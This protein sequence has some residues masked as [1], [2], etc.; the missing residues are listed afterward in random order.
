VLHGGAVTGYSYNQANELISEGSLIYTYSYNGDGL[1][2][3]K[4]HSV[5][6]F[7]VNEDYTWDV[8]AGLPLLLQDGTA[9]YIYGPGGQVLEQV[10]ADGTVYYDHTD[11]LGSVRDVTDSSGT[12]QNSYTYDPY[13]SV[14]AS[15]GSVT[16]PFQYAGE[17]QDAESGLIYLRARY[18]DPSTAQFLTRDSLLTE[19]PYAYV[20]GG[21]LTAVDPS[22]HDGF[23]IGGAALAASG[24]PA[25]MQRKSYRSCTTQ[26]GK[27]GRTK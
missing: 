2:Y 27:R 14:R 13:G 25:Q 22:G 8:M 12:V 17:Y 6:P 11:Q 10:R 3:R 26:Q 7:T 5:G 1:R 4:S 16:N 19:L 15:S 23:F 18:Y 20:A 24:R 9:S 21:P